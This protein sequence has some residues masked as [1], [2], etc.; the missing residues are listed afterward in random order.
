MSQKQYKFASD[1]PDNHKLTL[2]GNIFW[3]F[4]ISYV[5]RNDGK[6]IAR[7]NTHFRNKANNESANE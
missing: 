6:I 2:Q 4:V 5:A 3:I 7:T 1:S